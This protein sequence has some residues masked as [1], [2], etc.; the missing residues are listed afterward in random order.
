MLGLAVA[1][2][3]LGLALVAQPDRLA[4][5]ELE[6]GRQVVDLG[7][8]EVLGTEP[9]LLVRGD[10]DRL[11]VAVL[12]QRDAVRRVGREVRQ[13]DERVRERRRHRADPRDAHR[14]RDA[15]CDFA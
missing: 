13:V 12:G 10:R 11:A 6:R 2:Q 4:P 3:L 14:I 9:G 7:E 5:V 8:V 15:T 1:D